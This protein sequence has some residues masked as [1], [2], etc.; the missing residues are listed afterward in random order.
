MV[1]KE[2]SEGKKAKPRGRPFTKGHKRGKPQN[3]VLDVA[4]HESG[5]EGGIV[6]PNPQS[7][8]IEEKKE[9]QDAIEFQL[10]KQ[11]MET[12]QHTLKETMNTE[13]EEATPPKEE[14]KEEPKDLELID[15]LEFKNGENTLTIRFSKKHNRMFRIQ[16]YLN[17]ESEIRPVTYT[18]ASTGYAFWKLL[19][20]ALKK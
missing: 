16:V 13:Q 5:D 8:V 4:G 15:S 1:H 12:L 19:K 20:G 7:V 3:D 18:G 6:V 10:P 9:Q 2:H 17:D 11:G 14:P